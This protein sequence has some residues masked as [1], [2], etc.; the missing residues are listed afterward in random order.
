MSV[1]ITDYGMDAV[2]AVDAY[3]T[4]D[5]AYFEKW[6]MY[7]A[8]GTGS[9]APSQAD[10][11]LVSEVART[12]SNGGFARTEEKGTD[13]TTNT[14]WFRST[15]YRVFNFSSAYNLTEYGHFT[16]SSGANAVFRDLFRQNPNDP[17]SAAVTIS[18][19][20][21]DQLQIIKTFELTADWNNLAKTV[22]LTVPGGTDITLSGVQGWGGGYT[23]LDSMLAALWPGHSSGAF[24]SLHGT[25]T[26]DR[27][28]AINT[29][30]VV[31]KNITRDA[32]AA[33]TYT[34]R[35]RA[36]YSTADANKAWSG[37]AFVWSTSTSFM[38]P[39]FRFVFDTPDSFTKDNT[40]T[41][42]LLLDVSWSRG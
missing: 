40:H 26:T 14:V 39:S 23:F 8:V 42:E 13:S 1:R 30:G 34:R 28:Q 37:W 11:A 9:T 15:T 38:N 32:Y 29:S 16:S 33:G 10:T 4:G 35:Y 36:T 25:Q 12:S 19:Q 22:T 6:H 24:A 17:N 2:A 31:A 41:L 3:R 18:V 20:S 5:H 21:G 27:T 7:T